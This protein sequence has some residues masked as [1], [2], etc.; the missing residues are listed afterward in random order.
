MNLWEHLPSGVKDFIERHPK[1]RLALRG[2]TYLFS[3]RIVKIVVG[4]F[5]HALLARYLGPAQFGKMSYIIKTVTI[6]FAF[7]LFGVDELIIKH[8]HAKMKEESSILK[9]VLVLR[10]WMGGVGLIALAGFILFV[11]PDETFFSVLTILYGINILFQAFNTYELYFQ[12]HL[13]F[14]PLFIANNTSYLA[15]SA[16]RVLG[17]FAQW[18]MPFFLGTYL[19]GEIILKA[20]VI[21]QLGLK[22]AFSGIYDKELA[23]SILKDSWP[24][25]VS[26]FVVLSDQRLPFIFLELY[27]G[28]DEL[29]NFSV[30]ITLLDLWMFIPTAICVAIIPTIV[31]AFSNHK[32]AYAIRVQ[33]LADILTWI[34]FG[35]VGGVF[36]TADL[37]VQ[38][39]Y[40]E[41]YLFAAEALRWNSILTLISFFSLARLKW[42]TLEGRLMS[43][44]Y[45]GVVSLGINIALSSYL[46]PDH[47]IKGAIWASILAQIISN[48]V[49]C[50]FSK[51]LRGDMKIFFKTLS[52]PY[53]V[54]SKSFSKS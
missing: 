32:Q 23:K 13:N 44:M 41:K 20:F 30:A 45:L 24:F 50:F 14:R 2:L 8:F 5:V 15:S 29:G 6:F 43:W 42:M 40:G 9:T 53:R 48:I 52:F 37:V 12:N 38:V 18:S 27:R 7:G 3:E 36:L 22:K 10:L 33:Y 19:I 4:F 47:G 16:L 31:S 26:S 35:L 46:T 17:V 28:A 11:N 34:G 39:L 51:G 49:C 54:Y 1:S 21:G 25:F